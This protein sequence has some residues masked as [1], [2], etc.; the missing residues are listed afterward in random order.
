LAIDKFKITEMAV[1][2]HR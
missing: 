1:E 2:G